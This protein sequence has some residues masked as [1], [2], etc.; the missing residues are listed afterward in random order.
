MKLKP[1]KVSLL[2]QYIKKYLNSNSIFNN[3]RVEGE[4]SN[5]RTSNTGYTYFTLCD[6]SS[7]V[8]CICFYIN[9]EITDGDKIIVEGELSVYEF[10]G[11]YQIIVRKTETTGYGNI[12][13]ELELLKERLK[14]KGF[15]EK[16]LT[17]PLRPSKIGIITSKTGSALQDILKTFES[18]NAS[19]EVFIYNTLVQGINASKNIIDGIN[20]FNDTEKVDV[21]LISR[22]GG[23]FEDL[24]VFNDVDIAERIFMS[25]IPVVTGIGHETDRTLCDYTCDMYCHTPTAAAEYII[26]GYKELDNELKGLYIKLQDK[27]YNSLRIMQADLRTNKYILKSFIPLE[28]L[29]SQMSELSNLYYILKESTNKTINMKFNE[30]NLLNEMLKNKDYRN[31]LKNGYSL[32]LNADGNIISKVDDLKVDQDIKIIFDDFSVQARVNKIS[33]V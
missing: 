3:L 24:N 9:N 23:S 27:T 18:V 12:L 30:L 26:R 17:I 4:V 7:S 22:G 13:K 1:I 32:V 20:Y 2:N 19:F 31:Q 21:I 16:N 33:E 25:N 29:H 15:F 5:L 11:T 10:K 8:S 28:K 6:E 14:L